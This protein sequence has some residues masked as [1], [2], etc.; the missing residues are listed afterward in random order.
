MSE[1]RGQNNW[2]QQLIDSIKGLGAK[3]RTIYKLARQERIDLYAMQKFLR[4]IYPVSEH[5]CWH[6][7][8]NQMSAWSRQQLLFRKHEYGSEAFFA[9]LSDTQ[10]KTAAKRLLLFHYRHKI[11][12]ADRKLFI[13][14]KN[15]LNSEDET[16][17]ALGLQTRSLLQL[18][19]LNPGACIP[20][21][22]IYLKKQEA[23]E[24]PLNLLLIITIITALK[25]EVPPVR[26]LRALKNTVSLHKTKPTYISAPSKIKRAFFSI[27]AC[28]ACFSLLFLPAL[29]HRTPDT[30]LRKNLRKTASI[31]T[32][33]A[34]VTDNMPEIISATQQIESNSDPKTSPP[35]K[36]TAESLNSGEGDQKTTLPIKK[37]NPTNPLNPKIENHAK[38]KKI[39][40][41]TDPK[42]KTTPNMEPQKTRDNESSNSRTSSPLDNKIILLVG[43]ENGNRADTICLMT[44]RQNQV[45]VLNIPRDS[46]FAIEKDG[47][48]IQTK[49]NHSFRWGGITRLKKTL[50]KGLNITI[51]HYFTVSLELLRKAV[52]LIGGISLEVE[53]DMHYVDQAGKLEINLKAGFQNLQGADAEGYVRF[54]DA[55]EGDIGRIRRGQ[56]FIRAFLKKLQ[57]LQAF[58]WDG[59]S[60]LSRVPGFGLAVYNGCKTNLNINSFIELFTF[61]STRMKL[62]QMQFRVLESHGELLLDEAQDRKVWLQISNPKQREKAVSWLKNT[63]S[64]T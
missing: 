33:S 40:K 13:W 53:K 24:I 14:I 1:K 44:V 12:P 47:Q 21:H 26:L 19:N 42:S 37:P 28:A 48:E 50:E 23:T 11:S 58:S 4:E 60:F 18:K 55:Q 7:F 6:D 10:K 20:L 51:D 34:S 43:Y 29:F 38:P 35:E 32:E 45:S 15:A 63:D 31:Q 39:S 9:F 52:D 64:N 30:N 22:F 59:L 46:L 27:T 16:L 5:P 56:S 49:I 57:S 54:R 3:A 8:L 17:I 36:L 61:A 2:L 41:I 62:G 25:T